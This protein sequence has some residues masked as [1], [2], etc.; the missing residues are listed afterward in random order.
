MPVMYK[1]I[2]VP[3]K[4]EF[5]KR[6]F[7]GERTMASDKAEKYAEAFLKSLGVEDIHK[8]DVE[9]YKKRKDW[10]TPDFVIFKE[11]LKKN[12]PEDFYVDVQ[13]VTGGPFDLKKEKMFGK[14]PNTI[15]EKAMN[16][17][18]VIMITEDSKEILDAIYKPFHKKRKKYG[19]SKRKSPKF[20]LISV[21]GFEH[22][23]AYLKHFLTLVDNNIRAIENLFLY[24]KN[25]KAVEQLKNLKL[26]ILKGEK[27]LITIVVPCEGEDWIFWCLLGNIAY[28]GFG[29]M[30][31]NANSLQKIEGTPEH[32]WL[33]N[34]IENPR[35][36]FL[37]KLKEGLER[38][39]D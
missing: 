27:G 39:K 29:L 5:Y 8:S 13:E 19:N 15:R 3:T 34:L 21:Q 20:G 12:D 30:I 32:K 26:E 33:L 4:E 14:Y 37:D 31:I 24:A 10:L 25:D 28:E 22:N 35:L 38:I 7:E 9:K 17:H 16:S 6:W 18:D 1:G 36:E 11:E 2:E 23:P